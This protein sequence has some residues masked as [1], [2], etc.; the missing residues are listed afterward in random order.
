M[1]RELQGLGLDIGIF[2]GDK[3]E[4]AI[5]QIETIE[6]DVADTLFKTA[7]PDTTMEEIDLG[8]E[9]NTAAPAATEEFD[10]N[11]LFNLDD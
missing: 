8:F 2:T 5:E 7:E 1:I 4:V 3:K 10:E 6:S 11:S 9:D